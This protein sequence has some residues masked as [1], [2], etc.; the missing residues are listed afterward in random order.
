MAYTRPDRSCTLPQ[1]WLRLLPCFLCSLCYRYAEYKYAGSDMPAVGLGAGDSTRLTQTNVPV[2]KGL[3]LQGSS[4]CP[5]GLYSWCCSHL[6]HSSP[7]WLA[8]SG[9]CSNV[10]S[11]RALPSLTNPLKVGSLLSVILYPFTRFFLFFTIFIT[12]WNPN[13]FLL[14]LHVYLPFIL[15]YKLLMDRDFAVSGRA[16]CWWIFNE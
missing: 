12:A 1:L 5:R 10:T 3:M 13:Y 14:C 2:L 9:L 11:K 6:H 4:C 7:I 8:L 16:G 15:H